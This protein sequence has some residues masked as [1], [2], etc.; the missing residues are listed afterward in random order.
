MGA[1]PFQAFQ[2][3]QRIEPGH[4][5]PEHVQLE[6]HQFGIEPVFEDVH[7]PQPG[8]S[9]EFESVRAVSEFQSGFAAHLGRNVHTIGRPAIEIVAIA[10]RSG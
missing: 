4:T 6:R 2:E 10:A 5:G 7:G 9:G 1:R 8:A 3:F